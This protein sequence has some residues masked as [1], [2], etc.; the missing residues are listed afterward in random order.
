MDYVTPPALRAEVALPEQLLTPYRRVLA[1]MRPRDTAVAARTVSVLIAVAVLVTVVTLPLAP[2]LPREPDPRILALAALALVTAALMSV[3][4][5]FFDEASRLAWA[6]C[7]VTGVLVIVFVDLAT[8]DASVSAQIFFVFPAVYGAALLPRAG[9]ALMIALSLA[10]ELVVVFVL[11]PPR[12]ALLDATYMTAVLLTVGYLLLHSGERQARLVA[13]LARLAAVDPLTGLVT[14][15]T[16]DEALG[17]VLTRPVGEEGTSLLLLDV[18]EFKA[19]ND[20]Y[21]HPG[22]D[23]VLVQLGELLVSSSRRGDVVC[24]LG[25][26]ELAVLLPRCTIETA[27][28]RA[29]D[30]TQLVRAHGFEL[31]ADHPVT[32]SVSAGLAH[33]PTHGAD[34]GSLYAAAD[35][36]LYQAKRAGRDRVV[37]LD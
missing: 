27:R 1:W 20:R 18:D 11:L 3:A 26:D 2:A 30:I 25:G 6:L 16:F 10:G 33:A 5:W 7:P 19:V 34:P 23:Q 15:R 14:R 13:E 21:G 36:A 24:R 12:E 9:A 8:Y 31:G 4:A 17:D 35:A 22:G 37:A 29:E 32:V 28:R